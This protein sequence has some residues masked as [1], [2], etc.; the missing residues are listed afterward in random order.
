MRVRADY[1][2]SRGDD[3]VAVAARTMD[4]GLS[5]LARGRL[6]VGL[7]TTKSGRTIPARAGTTASSR[8]VPDLPTGLSPLARGRLRSPPSM[9]AASGTIP[10]RAGTTRQPARSAPRSADYPRSRGD[11]LASRNAESLPGGLSPLARGRHHAG[12]LH[13]ALGRTIPARAGTTDQR[14][15]MDVPA[16]D[17]PRSRGDDHPLSWCGPTGPGLSPLARGRRDDDRQQ[18][19]PPGTIPARAGTTVSYRQPQCGRADYPRSRGDDAAS[20]TEMSR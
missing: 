12:P 18:R 15:N 2:R 5:P 14:V 16:A 1:P 4:A 19:C 17:Y 13:E 20:R 9:A 6:E 7:E 11:D 8:G 3:P 10:A